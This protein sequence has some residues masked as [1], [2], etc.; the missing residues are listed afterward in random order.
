MNSIPYST[1]SIDK[2]DIKS[3]LNVLNS[4]FLTQGPLVEEFEN[5]ISTYCGS[6]YGVAVNS[7]TSALH[8]ACMALGFKKG[9]IL[10]TSPISFVASSNCA[11]YCGGKVDF[12][13]I[14]P[15]TYCMCPKKLEEKL[16]E[17]KKNNKLPKIVVPVHHTGQSCNMSKIYSLS[18]KFDF[19]IIE[20]AS[21]AL[22]GSFKNHKVGS[23]KY[24]DVTVLSFHPV[25][26]IT[27][28]EGGMACTNSKKISTKMR[29]LRTH[30]ITKNISEMQKK[31]EGPWYYEQI[32]LGY[33]YR[34][35]DIEAA[36]G[37]SQFRKIDKFVKERRKISV[38]YNKLL[39]SLPVI[40]PFELKESYSTYHLYI[41]L[42][43]LNVT[44]SSHIKVFNNLRDK[45]IGINLHYI[46][47]HTHPYYKKLGFK[48]GQFP[49]AETFYKSAISLPVYPGLTKK[50][51]DKVVQILRKALQN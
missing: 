13:D 44:H 19:K 5:K 29:L 4:K 48:Q 7:G 21:H 49:N 6:K 33:N 42:L 31:G 47:I 10:W 36:L 28:A 40:T 23:C 25:K 39:K 32:L 12:V 3:V 37:V 16:I 46:P 9:D 18:K 38:R 43:K 2:K 26:I 51:Q 35:N 27:T 11:L 45:G 1:Q 41:I 15:K 17:A 8:V 50:A 20:D 30:G 24:S 14:D 34:M 22:G